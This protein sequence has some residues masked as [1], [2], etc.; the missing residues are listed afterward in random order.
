MA[1]TPARF[2]PHTHI[3]LPV[4]FSASGSAADGPHTCATSHQNINEISIF[5]RKAEA[6]PNIHKLYI[7]TT[8]FKA[9]SAS[10]SVKPQKLQYQLHCI[11]TT[12]NYF[13]S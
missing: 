5:S 3:Y 7:D 4:M 11:V 13:I 10:S 6:I 9:V 2:M 8:M 12:F 1:L